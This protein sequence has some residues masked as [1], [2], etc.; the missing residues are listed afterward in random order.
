[1]RALHPR[2]V[3]LADSNENNSQQ[4]PCPSVVF[5]A[6]EASCS[7]T[8]GGSRNAV[9]MR[10]HARVSQCEISTAWRLLRL[11][12]QLFETSRLQ[13]GHGDSQQESHGDAAQSEA[14]AGL[15]FAPYREVNATGFSRRSAWNERCWKA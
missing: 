3:F 9:L 6:D 13:G 14:M 15:C 5:L 12:G 11:P 4:F 1:M 7:R 2:R 8:L 10:C